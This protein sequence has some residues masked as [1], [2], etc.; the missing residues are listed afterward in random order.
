MTGSKKIF[1]HK[2]NE[3]VKDCKTEE[4]PSTWQLKVTG[5]FL[6]HLIKYL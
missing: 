1:L 6:E 5:F 2:L 4:K 3:A